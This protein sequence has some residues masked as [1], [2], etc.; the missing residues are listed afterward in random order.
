MVQF[1]RSQWREFTD[2]VD[3]FSIMLMEGLLLV[4]VVMFALFYPVQV[5]IWVTATLLVALAVFET[6]VWIRHHPHHPHHSHHKDGGWHL[7]L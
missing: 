5:L 2:M 6:A 3:G 7:P 4:P 1:L